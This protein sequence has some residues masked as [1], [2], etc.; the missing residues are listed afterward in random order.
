[1]WPFRQSAAPAPS[2]PEG[3]LGFAIG[4]IHGRADLVAPALAR[5]EKEARS[6]SG[7]RPVAVFLGDYVDRGPESRR[8]LDLLT[9]WDAGLE[10]H[11]LR[12]NHEQAMLAFLNQAPEMRGWLRHGGA[13]TL[14]SYGV[15]PPQLDA[16]ADALIEASNALRAVIP[17]AHVEFLE[18]LERYV[19]FGDFLFVHA[20]VD[21]D[22]RLNEQTDRD[23]MWIRAPFLKA[24]R[25]FGPGVVVHGHTPSEAPYRDHRRIGLDTGAYATS[26]LTI[27]RFE[28]KDVQFL[29]IT[30]G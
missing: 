4:D 5:M 16:E 13:E 3:R 9:Q 30:P 27:A 20:G 11:F 18:G 17:P 14:V 12:G 15:R 21:P 2:F 28:G 8:T 23:L 22:K 24:K 1:M 19:Q 26:R 10:T 7:E 25:R 29:S 6:W